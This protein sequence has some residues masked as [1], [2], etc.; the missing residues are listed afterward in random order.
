MYARRGPQSSPENTR[1][2]GILPSATPTS[3]AWPRFCGEPPG[4]L[5]MPWGSSVDAVWTSVPATFRTPAHAA[6]QR[7]PAGRRTGPVGVPGHV[8]RNVCSIIRR[9]S[10]CGVAHADVAG[11]AARRNRG[12]PGTRISSQFHWRWCYAGPGCP[13]RSGAGQSERGSSRS[14][15]AEGHRWAARSPTPHLTPLVVELGRIPGWSARAARPRHPWRGASE[16]PTRGPTDPGPPKARPN[17]R[18][19]PSGVPRPEARRPARPS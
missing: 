13:R 5:C 7:G 16:P 6:A 15:P 2:C 12:G 4:P 10:S 3:S 19:P 14:R 11:A 8:Q 18:P 17:P 9:L 1:C